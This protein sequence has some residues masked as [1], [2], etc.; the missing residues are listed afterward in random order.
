MYNA[1]FA[2][3]MTE[4]LGNPVFAEVSPKHEVGVFIRETGEQKYFHEFNCPDAADQY[5]R[6]I[7]RDHP[8][9]T[10]RATSSDSMNVYLYDD[11]IVS[12][13][14]AETQA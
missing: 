4:I 6:N 9:F 10:A 2:Q 8:E 7:T 1:Q 11:G 13:C 5:A 14:F 12:A 3:M